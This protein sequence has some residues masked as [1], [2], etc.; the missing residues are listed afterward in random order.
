MVNDGSVGPGGSRG[1]I[2]GPGD[3]GPV[4]TGQEPDGCGVRTKGTLLLS[5]CPGGGAYRDHPWQ[6]RPSSVGI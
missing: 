4:G 1:T 3:G 6:E 5:V 2:S